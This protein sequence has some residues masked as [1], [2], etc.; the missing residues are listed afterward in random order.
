M[1]EETLLRVE[2]YFRGFPPSDTEINAIIEETKT[3]PEEGNVL[4]KLYMAEEDKVAGHLSAKAAKSKSK[5]KRAL[6]LSP[7]EIEKKRS[8][9][10]R[11]MESKSMEKLVAARNKLPI[12]QH[13]DAILQAISSHQVVLIAGETGCG[14]T[15]QV[16]QYILEECWS[17]NQPCRILCTQ[18][19]RIS[20]TSVAERIASERAEKL[21]INVGYTIRLDKK[22]SDEC[23]IMF[24]TNGIM[25]RMLTSPEEDIF[26]SLS[27]VV[28]D[29]IHERDRF[30]DFMLIIIRDLLGK[31][32][33]LRIILMSATLHEDLFSSYFGSCPVIRVPG[34]PYPV[35]D[36]YLEDILKLTG[37]QAAVLRQMKNEIGDCNI[38]SNLK[39]PSVGPEK[40]IEIQNAIEHAFKRGNEQDFLHLVDVTGAVESEEASTEVA[41]GINVQHGETGAT[42]LIAACF[43][44]LGDVI[45][46]LLANGADPRVKATNG[47]D[48]IDCARLFGHNNLADLLETHCAQSTGIDDVANA[49]LA[50][51]YY[52][53]HTDS[54]EVD[55]GLIEELL[56]C[57]CDEQQNDSLIKNT[58]HESLLAVDP[59]ANAILIF[60]P[61]WDEII[62]LKEKLEASSIFGNQYSYLI[63]P[64][65]SMVA[66]AEQTKVFIRPDVSVRKIILSTNVAETAITIDDVAFVIDSGKHKEKSYDPYT[67]ISTLQSGWISQASAKQRRG[68]AGRC[69]PGIAFH[70]YTRHRSESLEEYQLPEIMRTPLEEMGLQVKLLET[71]GN[72]IKIADFLSKAVEPPV[73]Q[74][75]NAAIKLLEAIGALEEGSEKL[76]VL[77]RHLASLPISPTLG[78]M[79]LYGV[80]YD[81]L[82]P[83]LT[84]SCCLGYR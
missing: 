61:G 21:G 45:G 62:R 20:A 83:I 60:L 34:F 57:I 65:H 14:K 79:L 28:I 26:G 37:Y 10:E 24:C 7:L 53:S 39:G 47:M 13:R 44:G 59:E 82:D 6:D 69:Q 19:R 78:K 64:L 74:A 4:S 46:T 76:T 36:F 43:H 52:Q 12:A 49:A 27:H 48:A 72:R 58:L 2:K 51:S 8:A 35:K 3:S 23:S 55:L 33:K 11:N 1:K 81:C 67:G 15:T 77:G 40:Q 18:P 56:L 41:P 25:L 80:I 32:P 68:R 9:W 50:V 63:L 70:L 30:A 29:E 16:P 42:P 73:L 66:P 71:P 22:G 54:D 84:V 75:V 31:Y 17:T 5:T 38:T